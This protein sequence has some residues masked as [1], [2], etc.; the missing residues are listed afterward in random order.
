MREEGGGASAVEDAAL[1]EDAEPSQMVE[2]E[3]RHKI[4]ASLPL[5]LLRQE[6]MREQDRIP[7]RIPKAGRIPCQN[8]GEDTIS[9]LAFFADNNSIQLEIARN[10]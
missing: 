1:R 2:E 9:C 6:T 3:N 10:I 5:D 8:K 7:H 4:M